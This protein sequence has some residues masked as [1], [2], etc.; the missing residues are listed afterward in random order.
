[1]NVLAITGKGRTGKTAVAAMLMRKLVSKD[2]T[3]LAI[4]ADPDP[5]LT[6]KD[7]MKN[8]NKQPT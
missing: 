2:K 1:M 3:I 8:N 4:D 6:L 7:V 5:N